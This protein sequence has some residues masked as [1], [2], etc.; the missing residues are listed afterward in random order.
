[1]ASY[2][3]QILQSRPYVEQLPL[4]AMAQVGMYK[5]AKYEENVQ[6]IQGEINRV[7]G[8]DIVKPIQKQYLQSKLNE[9]G[10]KLKTVAAGDF[11]N[12]QLTNSVGGMA[13]QIG[14]DTIVQGAVAS[15][16]RIRKEQ[17]NLETARSAGKSS[18]QNEDWWNNTLNNWLG[19]NN[20]ASQFSGRYVEYTDMEKKLREVAEKV[21]AYD[22]SIEIPYQRDN[23]GNVLYFDA[24]GNVTTK[25]RGQARV[26]DAILKTRVKGKSAQT[27]LDNFN[28]SLDPNDMQQLNIDGWYHYK[29]YTGPAFKNKI[30]TD[31]T[32]TFKAKR[33]A[34]SDELVQMTAQLA[35]N[36]KLTTEERNALQAKINQYS[37]YVNGGGLDKM[38]KDKID[39]IDRMGETELKGAV[40]SEKFLSNLATNI[41]YQD[42]E[43][44]Y[45]DNPYQKAL[46]DRKNLQFD[47][48]KASKEFE[49]SDRDYLLKVKAFEYEV[50]KDLRTAQG[51]DII[52]EDAG[53]STD[54]PAPK[55][56]D[57]VTGI[58]TLNDDITN[59]K[60]SN[61]EILL[62]KD[63]Y[64]ALTDVQRSE[65]IS[66]MLENYK[67]NPTAVK[68]NQSRKLLDRYDAMSTDM[69]RRMGNYVELNKKAKVFDDELNSIKQT[70]PGYSKGNVQVYTGKE[71]LDVAEDDQFKGGIVYNRFGVPVSTGATDWNAMKAKYAGTKYAPLVD[72]IVKKN[73]Q[74]IASLNSEEAALDKA[75]NNASTQL[76]E[77]GGDVSKRRSEFLTKQMQNIMPQYQKEAGALDIKDEQTAFRINSVLGNMESIYNTSVGRLNTDKFDPEVITQW[78]TGKQKDA[79]KYVIKRSSDLSGGTLQIINGTQV[80][81]IPLEG[82]N[83]SKYFP[84][85]AKGNPLDAVKYMIM[86]SPT[87]TTNA[88]GSTDGGPS[89]A[90][91]SA[92]TGNEL[93]LLQGTGLASLVRFDIEG[94]SDNNGGDD[95]LYQIRMY[96]NDNGVWKSDVVNEQGYAK[97]DGVFTIM[98]NIGTKKYQEIKSKE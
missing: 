4:E 1:M 91:N 9:L 96:V 32:D 65:A 76:V 75:L 94:D 47:Y 30:I 38:M 74:G 73:T 70:L 50:G 28:S 11:S 81:E 5:Q 41:A 37:D 13:T 15:T 53:L 24:R 87:R 18:I 85:A 2:T 64:D 17:S 92:F 8:L 72:V 48:W 78:T 12:F 31:I 83:L 93:P 27:I 90:I 51:K 58:N 39:S 22:T 63:K 54:L 29:G 82:R 86:S 40:Y 57:L 66:K 7:A 79:L 6:K 68:D 45:K 49:K 69:T 20:L 61:A 56:T 62:G 21:H 23:A 10:G 84:Q 88:V 35:S 33:N 67:L 95:D 60:K 89:G 16:Q 80:Q 44:E 97:L 42:K 43:I 46:M 36:S 25:E 71:L 26:D 98:Q 59:F 14:N 19:D 52:W 77:K 3:D 55:I 34:A